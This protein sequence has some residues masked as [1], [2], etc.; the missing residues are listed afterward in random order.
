[1]TAVHILCIYYINH[2]T[3]YAPWIIFYVMIRMTPP[4]SFERRV[5]YVRR[6]HTYWYISMIGLT[7]SKKKKKKNIEC[8]LKN[9]HKNI[10]FNLICFWHLSCVFILLINLR[11]II[12]FETR[13]HWFDRSKKYN[14]SINSKTNTIIWIIMLYWQNVKLFW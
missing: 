1:M 10:T 5:F 3:I 14:Q 9:G 7:L 2:I 8:E 6:D 11:K 13:V 4:K 12:T